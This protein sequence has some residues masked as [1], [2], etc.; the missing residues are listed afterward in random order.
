MRAVLHAFHRSI[1]G[2]R[3]LLGVGL[4]TCAGLAGAQAGAGQ[5]EELN[6]AERVMASNV[7][8]GELAC[9]FK[10]KVNLNPDPARPGHFL[11]NTQGKNFH[12]RPVLTSTGAVRL[13]DREQGAVW[14]Q[15]ANKSMLMNQKLGRRLADEC[16]SPQQVAV[17]EQF[18]LQPPPNLLDVARAPR[19]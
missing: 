6:D 14:L 11:L 15:L 2:S 12:L 4:M 5:S 1:H 10:Q 7:H 19:P 13:E 18:K 9:E 17:A 16:Q 8:V 3:A